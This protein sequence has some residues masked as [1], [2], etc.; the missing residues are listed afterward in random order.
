MHTMPHSRL[1][2][3]PYIFHD[4][5]CEQL[6]TLLVL[7]YMS[8]R[9]SCKPLSKVNVSVA[10]VQPSYQKSG[11]TRSQSLS[12]CWLSWCWCVAPLRWE[13]VVG[14][15]NYDTHENNFTCRL[16]LKFLCFMRIYPS[17][18]VCI[19]NLLVPCTYFECK[20]EAL[21]YLWRSYLA[22]IRGNFSCPRVYQENLVH[23]R[24]FSVSPPYLLYSSS[25]S[26]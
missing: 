19:I 9:T 3:C 10:L 15:Q 1:L 24:R 2:L 4:L 16:N 22:E 23:A 25:V 12:E 17:N 20:Y 6:N 11:W 26:I 13:K 8:Q 5:Y 7:V 21:K 14:W 18:W